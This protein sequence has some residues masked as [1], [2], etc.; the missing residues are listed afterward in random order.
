MFIIEVE[1]LDPSAAAACMQAAREGIDRG[2]RFRAAE[3]AVEAARLTRLRQRLRYLEARARAG[4]PEL[5]ECLVTVAGADGI[6]RQ[7]VAAR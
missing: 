5:P 6:Y 4:R 1:R 3:Q 2:E 7:R